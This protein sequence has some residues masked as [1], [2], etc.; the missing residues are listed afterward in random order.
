MDYHIC[1]LGH[2]YTL[3]W[4]RDW[5]G[6]N[7]STYHACGYTSR[8]EMETERAKLLLEIGWTPPRWWQ[9]WRSRDTVL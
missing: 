2:G 9:F 4:T 8:E 5:T 7:V 6:Q 1:L 3:R